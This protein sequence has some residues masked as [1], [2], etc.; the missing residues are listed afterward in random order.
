ME[1]R[2]RPR[3]SDAADRGLADDQ[4]A[5]PRFGRDAQRRQSI[6]RTR[7]PG[8]L[9]AGEV[10]P[11]LRRGRARTSAAADAADA[12]NAETSGRGAADT[13][14]GATASARNTLPAMREM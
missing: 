12:E 2:Q 11:R 1:H 4:S 8:E 3:V 6:E 14:A 13:V 10:D 9:G 7:A 5:S